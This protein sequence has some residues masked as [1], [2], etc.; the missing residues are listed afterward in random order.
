[1]YSMVQTLNLCLK[2][3]WAGVN[4]WAGRLQIVLNSSGVTPETSEMK[5]S[6][7]AGILLEVRNQPHV[8]KYETPNVSNLDRKMPGQVNSPTTG[9]ADDGLSILIS[10]G[11]DREI[12]Q[13]LN[14]WRC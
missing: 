5:V 11:F 3:F 6:S 4:I 14:G 10:M 8:C 1:M 9:D 12:H 2:L 13:M 7:S